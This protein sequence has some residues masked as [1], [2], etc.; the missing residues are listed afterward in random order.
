[1][2]PQTLFTLSLCPCVCLSVCP[3]VTTS[4]NAIA[5]NDSR[6]LFKFSTTQFPIA[7]TLYLFGYFI[8]ELHFTACHLGW[9][10]R[11]ILFVSFSGGLSN[12]LYMCQLPAQVPIKPGETKHAMLRYIRYLRYAMNFILR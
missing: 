11:S 4:G 8:I 2:Y 7:Y 12:Y 1:M 5:H 9:L 10:L 6:L 3:F